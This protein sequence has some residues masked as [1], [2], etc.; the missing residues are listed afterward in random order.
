MPR[1][2]N[3][4]PRRGTAPSA[5]RSAIAERLPRVDPDRAALFLPTH[6]PSRSGAGR[7]G[8]IPAHSSITRLLRIQAPSTAR[9]AP[10]AARSRGPPGSRPR[11]RATAPGPGR[12]SSRRRMQ[13][14]RVP[15]PGGA[16]EMVWTIAYPVNQLHATSSP[17]SEGVRSL[18]DDVGRRPAARRRSAPRREPRRGARRIP[19]G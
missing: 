17:C 12:P 9:R 4:P 2:E 19:R 14:A 15:E 7:C 6:G 1:V 11:R 3:A 13:P 16:E 5:S 10:V 8:R 18:R